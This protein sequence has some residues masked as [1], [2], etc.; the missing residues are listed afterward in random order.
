MYVCMRSVECRGANESVC[1]CALY[2]AES[3]SSVRVFRMFR[4]FE[5]PSDQSVRA[6]LSAKCPSVRSCPCR[7]KFVQ[8]R[9][10]RSE[11]DRA[12][13]RELRAPVARVAEHYN[14]RMVR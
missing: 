11:G 6:K 2:R 13:D 4:V 10:A 1:P 9:R 5:C 8:A 3:E 12:L 7:A 14:G